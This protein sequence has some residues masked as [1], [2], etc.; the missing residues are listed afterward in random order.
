MNQHGIDHLICQLAEPTFDYTTYVFV[1]E[2]KFIYN[3]VE[4]IRAWF[5]HTKTSRHQ[6][7]TRVVVDPE[8]QLYVSALEPFLKS[9]DRSLTGVS[10]N[11]AIVGIDQST[12]KGLT[13]AERGNVSFELYY[14]L[15][16]EGTL[17]WYS[18]R[19]LVSSTTRY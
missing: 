18:G 12:Y 1:V 9:A 16:E 4:Q 2:Q 19:K 3:V 7:Y 17:E 10:I 6:S 11:H 15:L 14:R 8:K 13:D 5:P